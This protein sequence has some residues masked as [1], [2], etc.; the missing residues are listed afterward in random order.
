[1]RIGFI[2][3]VFPPEPEPSSVMAAELVRAWTAAGHEVFVIC[4]LPN[5]PAGILYPGFER[6]PWHVGSYHG[7]RCTRVWSWLIGE[8]RRPFDRVLENVSF[9][10]MSSLALLLTERPDVVILESWPVLASSMALAVCA[11][12]GVRVVNYIKDIYPEAATAAGAIPDGSLVAAVLARIDRWVCARADRNVVISQGAARFLRGA[13][14]LP[15]AKIAVVPDWLDL[16]SIAPT[17][18]GP[19]WRDEAGIGRDEF[20][21]MFAGTMGLVSRSDILVE[22]A[23]RLRGDPGIRLVCVGQGVLKPRM[24]E[25][26]ARRGLKNLTLLPFQPR[27]RVADVQSAADVMLLTASAQMGT[28]SVPNK[29]IT[30]LAVAKPVICAVPSDSDAAMLVNDHRLGV[31]VPPEDP[32]ALAEAIRAMAAQDRATLEEMGRRSRAV[33]L[34]RYSARSAAARFER[35]FAELRIGPRA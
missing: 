33:A 4:P 31:V 5:R 1:M 24:E 35:L 32:S 13:R 26:I 16:D 23:D 8:E 9:G 27:E 18:G 22:V 17:G 10:V 14:G 29:L 19:A 3:A 15:A 21:C 34:A 30:Y 28:T 20:V 11:A 25:E 2:S 12:R 6:R 7:A